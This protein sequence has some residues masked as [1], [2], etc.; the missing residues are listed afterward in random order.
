LDC[1]ENP[2]YKFCRTRLDR[3]YDDM[4]DEDIEGI[5]T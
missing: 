2:M 1:R 5:M 4:M 3:E